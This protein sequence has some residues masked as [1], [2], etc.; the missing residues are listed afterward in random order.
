MSQTIID[1]HIHIWD[2]GRAEYDWLKN[3]T[4]IL[5]RNYALQ[6]LEPA[7]LEAGITGGILVQAANNKEDTAWMLQTA[8]ATEWIK[9]VV[10]WL[11]LLQP[12]AT[13]RALDEYASNHWFKG[14]RHLVH[15]EPDARWLLQPPVLESLRLL[16]GHGLPYDMVGVIPAHIETALQVA[17]QVPGLRIVFDHLN[18]PPMAAKERFGRWGSLLKAA[19]AHPQFFVKI[20]GLGTASGNAAGWTAGDTRPY[21]EFVLQQFGP[22][23]C[24]CGGDWP[25]SLLA[26]SYTQT[27]TAY[28]QVLKELL[29]E[30]EQEQVLWKTAHGFYDL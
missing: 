7:R 25:V 29:N 14:M 27:W 19:A 26:G 11:P 18:Q 17:E 4:S 16:A 24:L 22:A 28:R 2:F 21:I 3:D 1:T 10:G 8:A 9:G 12:E 6:E 15:D 23:R 5:H 13:A 20:S 30:E